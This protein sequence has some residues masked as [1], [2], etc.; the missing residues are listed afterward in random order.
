MQILFCSSYGD[1]SLKQLCFDVPRGS[2]VGLIGENGAGKSTTIN[3]ILNE[4]QKNSGKILL[5]GKDYLQNEIAS[6]M[7]GIY[8]NWN[9][10][11]YREYLKKFDLPEN[12]AIKGFSKGMKVKLAFAVALSHKAELLI[13]DEATSGLDP[14]IRDDILDILLDFVQDENHADFP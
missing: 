1:F 6:Y 12:K 4:V 3:C 14:V 10:G 2:I 11:V 13:L 9:T 5:F 7:S 8:M